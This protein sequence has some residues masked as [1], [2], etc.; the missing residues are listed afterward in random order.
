[1]KAKP[2]C[3]VNNRITIKVNMEGARA[4]HEMLPTPP[5]EEA[6]ENNRDTEMQK[7]KYNRCENRLSGGD[8]DGGRQEEEAVTTRSVIKDLWMSL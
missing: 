6:K 3:H 4:S 1:M 8:G 2:E 5:H 7:L